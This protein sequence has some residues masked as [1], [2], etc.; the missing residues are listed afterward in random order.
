[1]DKKT[2]SIAVSI[3]GAVL[4]VSQTYDFIVKR[5]ANA[6]LPDG[7]GKTEFIDRCSS[8]HNIE[9]VI[10]T[11]KSFENWEAAILWMQKIQGMSPLPQA[12]KQ[13][14]IN[15]LEQNFPLKKGEE[16]KQP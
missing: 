9:R 7:P 6:L 4:I 10:K 1:M 5:Q 8:C 13:L 16:G 12:E 11:Q 15:Y 3:L 14:L 2:I